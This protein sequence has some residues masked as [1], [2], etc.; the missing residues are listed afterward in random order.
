MRTSAYPR[1]IESWGLVA[2]GVWLLCAPVCLHATGTALAWVDMAVGAILLV[3][4]L[5]L[6]PCP[7]HWRNTPYVLLAAVPPVAMMLLP[8]TSG[9]VLLA[10]LLGM[11]AIAV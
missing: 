4:V 6:P 8:A 1:D 5:S 7:S 10:N 9:P 3:A 2:A 11:A